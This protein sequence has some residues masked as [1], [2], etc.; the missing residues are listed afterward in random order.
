MISRDVIQGF[1]DEVVR[2]FRPAKVILFGS[3]AYGKPTEDSDVDLMLIMPHRGPSAKTAT[4]VRLACPR[5]FPMDLIVRSPGEV[6]R[7]LAQGDA[8]LREITS[9][10][11]VLHE[12]HDA[13][14]G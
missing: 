5:S 4:R 7:R 10:G 1:V 9:R 3:Y 12:S 11:V 2:R 13:R 6:R 8:F 14:M